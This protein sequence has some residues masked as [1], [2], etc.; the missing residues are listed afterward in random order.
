MDS[1]TLEGPALQEEFVNYTWSFL[2]NLRDKENPNFKGSTILL[3]HVPMYK[4]EGLCRDGPEH[5]Y[6]ENYEKEPYKNGKLR[7][8]NHLA[9]DTTQR[10]MDIVFPNKDKNGMIFTGHDHEGCDDWYNY[11]NGEW[12]ASKDKISKERES[13]REIVVRSMM[14]EYNGET[15]ILTGHFNQ[16]QDTWD[17]NFSYCTFAIQHW[18]WASKVAIL[19][20]ILLQSIAKI[21]GG[22]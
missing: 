12:V 8:H 20:A 6:Y 2:E 15:G 17:F 18:W 10:V 5:R 3:T 14:G 16:E 19:I 13:V 4:I 9:Y 21:A 7:S 1:L 11:I 22:V